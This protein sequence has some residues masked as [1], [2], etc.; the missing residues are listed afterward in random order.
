MSVAP[1]TVGDVIGDEVEPF[2]E[3]DASRSVGYHTLAPLP[4]AMQT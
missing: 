3:L 4:T 2:S 1:G